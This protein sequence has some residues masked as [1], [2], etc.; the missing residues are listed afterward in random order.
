M[1]WPSEFWTPNNSVKEV[2]L[3][4]KVCSKGFLS[5]FFIFEKTRKL[6]DDFVKQESFLMFLWNKKAF[7]L[8]L[9]I[10]RSFLMLPWNKNV[11][12]MFSY[13][14]EA[15]WKDSNVQSFLKLF[16][17]VSSGERFY[18]FFQLF[19]WNLLIKSNSKLQFIKQTFPL[20]LL[21]SKHASL[22]VQVRLLSIVQ[23]IT[24]A[25]RF[26]LKNKLNILLHLFV[27]LCSIKIK[28]SHFEIKIC[29]NN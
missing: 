28:I 18:R 29:Q 5:V 20:D 17:E 14:K 19:L 6:S 15:F 22:R 24:S 26:I 4:G 2:I 23:I 12:L 11:F 3:G 13:S 7:V 1:A 9:K 25:D 27:V 8:F 21:S 16:Q 10:R